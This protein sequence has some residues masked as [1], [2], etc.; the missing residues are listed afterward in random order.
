MESS[1]PRSLNG[2]SQWVFLA[3][4]AAVCIPAGAVEQWIRSGPGPEVYVRNIQIFAN[5]PTAGQAV[6]YAST[7]GAGVVRITD[8]GTSIAT[9]QLNNG[10]PLLRIRDID[11]PDV[12]T[13]YAAVDGWGVYKSVNGGANWAVANGSGGS[14]LGCLNVRNMTARSASEVWLVT[15]CRRSSGIYRSLDGAATW[16]RIGVATIP[17]D[18]AGIS[19]AFSGT[20]PTTVAVLATARDGFFRSPDNGTTWTQINTGIPAPAG[21][22]R[23]TAFNAAFLSN[24]SSMLGYVEGQGVFR[25]TNA[26]ATWTPWGTG[27]AANSN[28]LGGISRESASIFY[29]GTEKG[30]VYKTIDGGQNWAAWG[31]TGTTGGSAYARGVSSDATVTGRRWLHGTAGLVRTDDNATTF[32]TVTMPEGYA[33]GSNID[34]NGTTAY[35][36]SNNSIYRISDLYNPD[37]S[38]AIDIGVALPSIPESVVADPNNA[39][40]LYAALSNRGLYKTVNGGTTWTALNVPG[41]EIGTN[42]NIEL[43]TSDSQIVYAILDNK[44]EVIAG[45][46]VKKSVNGGTTWADSSIGLATVDSR[47]VNSIAVQTDPTK[48]LI[49]TGDGI[50]R[51][52]NSGANWG[53]VYSVNDAFATPLPFGAIRFDPV[54]GSI[55]WAAAN[56]VDPDGTVRPS[57]GIYKSTDGGANWA[58]V[59]SGKRAIAVRPEANG[60]VIAMFNRDLSQAPLLASK[61]GGTTWQSFSTG[62]LEND[63]IGATRTPTQIGSHLVMAMTASGIYVLD[64]P[65]LTV[66]VSGAGSV[67][68]TPAAITCPG[69]CTAKIYDNEQVTLTAAPAAGSYF[70]GWS[71]ACTGSGI[72]NVTMDAVKSVGAEF[73]LNT[74]IPR[75]VNIS[76]RGQVLTGNDVMIGGFIIGG[77]APKTVVVR[78][79]GPS[80]IPFGVANALANPRMD[81]Y[82]GQ[83]IIAA[84]DNWGDAPNAAAITASGFAPTDALESAIHIILSPGAYTAVVSGVNNVTGV[85]I[86]EVFEVN[87]PEIPL[88]NISTRGQVL[89]NND[90]MIGGFIIQGDAPQTVFVRARGPSLVPFGIPNALM[91]P[92]LQLFAGQTPIATN[93]DWQVQAIPA[94]VAAI[95]AS[96]FAPTDSREA[97]IR[98]TLQP[99][100]Y[101]AIV[102][103]RNGTTGVG[104]VEVFAQ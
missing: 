103:G 84:N 92:V 26:G 83:V 87:H 28:S 50:Y 90:V 94:D 20:G 57:S 98:V 101:T 8:N 97:V 67:A 88:I 14:A 16:S 71:G 73:K 64:K 4:L 18:A 82:S 49:S 51:S 99:G 77:S 79:R 21:A 25:T 32:A 34:V 10:L 5:T 63:G 74:T 3:A 22:N 33:T 17:D 96:P 40:T 55:A 6:V 102:T 9:T 104:I 69:T 85:G 58:Q 44:F 30:P 24:S 1:H 52:T 35:V 48:L 68:S 76:T 23:V 65:A 31:N 29:L 59:L 93:D 2:I 89:T 100:A 80:M 66:T 43:A 72:C 41:F 15:S 95:Q 19:I 38:A 27:I 46:G 54:N 62:I 53:L 60:R 11:A 36:A 86:V 75:L 7:L 61:D 81:L 91:D 56:H 47:Q 12:N 70:N 42:P 37:W 45:G 13:L 78:A 39:G